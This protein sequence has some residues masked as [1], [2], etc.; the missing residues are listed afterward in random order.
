MELKFKTE[1][2]HTVDYNDLDNFILAEYGQRFDVVADL[3]SGNDSQHVISIPK[4][5]AL[6]EYNLNALGRFIKEGTGSYLTQV[7]LQDL[8]N[9]NRIPIGDYLIEV[10]W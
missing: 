7:L 3:E 10:C 4:K 1:T 5:I 8:V 6:D 2:V 9:K